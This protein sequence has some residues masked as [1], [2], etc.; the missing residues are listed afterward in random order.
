MYRDLGFLHVF[1]AAAEGEAPRYGY[2]IYPHRPLIAYATEP[3]DYAGDGD[4]RLLNE[5]WGRLPWIAAARG[6][7]S[8]CRTR[9]TSWPSGSRST[10]TGD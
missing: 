8:V 9:T 1:G 10:R 7:A 2:L 5:C 6:A 3:G 4:L